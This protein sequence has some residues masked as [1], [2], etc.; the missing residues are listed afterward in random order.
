MEFA[1]R[2]H[3]KVKQRDAPPHK[4]KLKKSKAMKINRIR[5][6]LNIYQALPIVITVVAI[7]LSFSADGDERKRT[8]K[9]D[10]DL[11]RCG[12]PY[13]M[14]NS[15]APESDRIPLKHTQATVNVSGVIANVKVEQ[16]YVNEGENVIEAI[17]VFPGSTNAAVHGMTMQI[18]E[19]RIEAKI[20]EKEQARAAYEQAKS[21]GK[22]VSLLEQHRPNV[23]QMNV[24][25]ILPGDSLKVE[26]RY[27][28][29]LVPTDGVY[30]FVYPTVVGP[31]YHGDPGMALASANE[32]WVSNPYQS[33][34]EDPLYTFNISGTINAGMP[35]KQAVCGTHDLNIQFNGPNK[36]V[37]NSYVDA[38]NGGNKDV[39]LKYQLRGNKVETGVLLFEGKDENFFLAM[40]EPPKQVRPEQIPPREYVFVVDVSGSMNGFPLTVSK[41]LMRELLTGLRPS[42]SF[43]VLLFASGNSVLSKQSLPVTE[44]NI[45]K[46]MRLID[47]QHGSGGTQ[48]LPALKE[49]LALP[50]EE[51]VSRTM[52]I[53]TDGYV[54]VDRE[55]IDFIRANLGEA[56]F[57]SFGI[58]SSVNRFLIEGMAQA[59]KGEPFVLT[60]EQEAKKG[61]KKFKT[62]IESPV[63]TDIKIEL[64][65]FQAYDVE[66]MNVPDVF[67]ERP[68]IVFGKYKGSPYGKLKITGASGQGKYTKELPLEPAFASA[69]NEALKYLWAR[70][71][72]QLLDDFA[73]FGRTEKA[74]KE[75]TELGLKYNLLTQYTSFVAIDSEVRNKGGNQTTI[76]QPLP[77][78][79]GVSDMAVGNAYGYAGGPKR[80]FA[81]A[82]SMS[83]EYAEKAEGVR[84]AREQEEQR[85]QELVVE[86]SEDEPV[87]NI[88]YSNAEMKASYVG[89]SAAMEAFIKKSLG[90]NEEEAARWKQLSVTVEFVVKQ[91]GSIGDVVVKGCTDRQLK[92]RILKA[93]EKMPKWKPAEVSGSKVNSKMTV[94]IKIG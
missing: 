52:V 78:P 9:T 79:E 33:E 91:D 76:V 86:A 71:R 11:E 67:A 29:L 74:K 18:G 53:A 41:S 70:K 30:S 5:S 1:Q 44:E 84:Y 94:P 49:A 48:L 42:D 62:Y 88:I 8:L 21:D 47:N 72:I 31:R 15:D 38:L 7:I 69:D 37:F 17:Y 32:G 77:L 16:V 66:P 61:A 40:L 2:P 13:L 43:N 3:L 83:M 24:A 26:L 73:Q 54:S 75:V 58:G 22:T 60:S 89:G 56:N 36:A 23:F 20:N 63:L 68:V 34:G 25:N 81:A 35:I 51:G 90:L 55:A 14:V 19:R 57:F 59:G 28:E 39:I 4:V 50:H 65:G 45:A 80:K 85:R 27:T 87:S 82:E 46:A 12:S 64:D 10:T 6:V 93:F 92:Q